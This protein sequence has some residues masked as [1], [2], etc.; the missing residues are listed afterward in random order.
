VRGS[1]SHPAPSTREVEGQH[2]DAGE[3]TDDRDEDEGREREP[4]GDRPSLRGADLDGTPSTQL[5][6]LRLGSG[7]DRREERCTDG[8]CEQQSPTYSR[9]ERSDALQGCTG[10][11]PKAHVIER[12]R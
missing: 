2:R 12:R 9:W 1:R 10:E 4:P 5:I 11:E 6:I 8:P 3:P 7:I